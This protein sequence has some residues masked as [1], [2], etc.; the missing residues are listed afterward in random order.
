MDSQERHELK[1]NDLMEFFTHFR[2]WWDKH[3]TNT[4]L[5][6]LII[7]AGAVGYNYWSNYSS[8]QA[9]EAWSALDGASGPEGMADV[10]AAYGQQPVADFALLRAADQLMV[11]ARH[12]L[13]ATMVGEEA[14]VVELTDEQVQARLQRAEKF[15]QQVIDNQ[16]DT[17]NPP[18]A[19]LNAMMGLAAVYESTGRFDEAEQTYDQVIAKAGMYRTIANQAQQQ[20]QALEQI[21][22]PV[23]FDPAPATPQAEQTPAAPASSPGDSFSIPVDPPDTA[24]TSS[25]TTPSNTPAGS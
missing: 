16:P 15:Y 22:T 3:G 14:D 9:E 7:L 24:P 17:A 11:E 4:L 1:Q 2:E 23:E 8:R 18:L 12:G 5:V 6:V 19:M 25:P 10:A 21:R 13:Q 20:R